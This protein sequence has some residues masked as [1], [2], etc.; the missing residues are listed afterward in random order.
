VELRLLGPASIP[1]TGTWKG[2][3]EILAAMRRNFAWLEQQ[4]VTP[5]TVVAQGDLVLVVAHEVGIYRLTGAR[6]ELHFV[7]EFLFDGER[8]RRIRQIVDGL[9][10]AEAI[11][12]GVASRTK[13]S[14]A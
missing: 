5:Q 8:V 7:Q 2:L 12:G 6:Y 10:L 11:W 4:N 13:L 3:D 9:Q 14:D 1:I